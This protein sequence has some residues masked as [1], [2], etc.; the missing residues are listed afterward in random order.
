MSGLIQLIIA[1]VVIIAVPAGLVTA[2]TWL[3]T[4]HRNYESNAPARSAQRHETLVATL[5]VLVGILALAA[6]L[7]GLASR[8]NAWPH[9]TGTG[10]LLAATPFAIAVVYCIARLVGEQSWPR[11]L[12]EVRV[13]PVTRRTIFTTGGARLIGLLTTAGLLAVTLIVTGLTA[14]SSG[15]AL[16][17]ARLEHGELITTT[18]SPYPGWYYALPMLFGLVLTVVAALVTLTFITRRPPLTGLSL[19]H[20]EAIRRTSAKRLLAGLQ[21]CLGLALGVVL[22]FTGVA[23]ELVAPAWANR[24]PFPG[25]GNLLALIGWAIAIGSGVIALIG[26]WPHR[27]PSRETQATLDLAASIAQ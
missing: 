20:D 17:A 11:P 24:A 9:P 16:S 4:R 15:R 22:R 2:V 3:V 8:Y 1:Y 23:I 14:D 21:L 18:N 6:I 19:A 7:G 27:V 10:P 13:A 12:G 26:F 25:S 5:S